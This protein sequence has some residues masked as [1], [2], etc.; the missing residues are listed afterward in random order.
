MFKSFLSL[1][2]H[3]L[4]LCKFFLRRVIVGIIRSDSPE[5]AKCIGIMKVP[6]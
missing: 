4:R 1:S 2:L 6:Y 5:I 3:C